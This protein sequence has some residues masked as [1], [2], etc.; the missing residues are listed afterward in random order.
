MRSFNGRNSALKHGMY[1][2][3]EYISWQ[4]MKSRCLNKADKDYCN[5][6]GI[7]ITVCE[8]W[9][10][11]FSDFYKDMGSKPNSKFTI[12][13]ISVY[14]NYEPANCRWASALTQQRNRRNSKSKAD[15]DFIDEQIKKDN[16]TYGGALSRLKR[17]ANN[18]RSKTESN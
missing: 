3:P 1:R 13:R 6:G 8:R 5:Y 10:R 9:I 14:G 2:S 7:G 16:I 12:D 18:E 15:Y 11:S 4:S 17:K